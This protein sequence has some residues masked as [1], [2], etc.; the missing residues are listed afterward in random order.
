M[1]LNTSW[2][3]IKIANDYV[4][5]QVPG[6]MNEFVGELKDENG[7]VIKI[8]LNTSYHP[9]HHVRLHA[10]VVAV[11][12]RLS[13]QLEPLYEIYPGCPR[14]LQARDTDQMQRQ[15]NAMP[16]QY[17]SRHGLK[18]LCGGFKPEFKTLENEPVEVPVG[19]TV[20]FHYNSLLKAENYLERLENGDLLYRIPYSSIFC[21]IE[22]EG[23]PI[24]MLNNYCLVTPYVD[25]KTQEIEMPGGGKIFGRMRGD[26]VISLEESK[27][28]LT[29]ILRHI[30]RPIGPDNRKITPIG[31][32]I[33]YRPSSEFVNNIEGDPYYVMRS[34]DIVAEW[35]EDSEIEKV[36]KIYA[37]R[38]Q[39]IE[40]N[41]IVPVGDY[42]MITPE[43]QSV[44]KQGQ[45]IVFDP[46]NPNQKFNQGDLFV[47]EGAFSQDKKKKLH[48][49]G[50]GRVLFSGELCE[51]DRKD[52]DVM[53]EKSGFYLYVPEFN[54]VFVREKDIYGTIEK[55]ITE[56]S[57]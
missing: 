33:M 3:K 4:I 35:I 11:P 57:R 30:G 49:F 50:V 47:P 19:S 42:V 14:P 9:T 31:A 48:K 22:Y 52:L 55:E 8:I 12:E 32:L 46:H 7:K 51:N 27:K 29:G 36:K 44:L 45:Q 2:K 23:G 15:I 53:Y 39:T 40:F 13:E 28:Y 25:E 41:Q 26:L 43:A 18:Y 56:T 6:I 1:P 54:V 24:N 17:R 10:K 38:G 34:T 5:V 16:P 37:L 21:Y 20:Y